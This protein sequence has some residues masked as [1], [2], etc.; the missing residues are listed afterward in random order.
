M[1]LTSLPLAILTVYG[2]FVYGCLV[3]VLTTLAEV[4]IQHYEFTE[5]PL[6]LTFLG[7]G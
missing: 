3:L 4:F 5:G 7:I 6:G 1:L 2:C